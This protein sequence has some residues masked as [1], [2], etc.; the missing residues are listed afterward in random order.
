MKEKIKQI[1]GKIFS[2]TQSLLI[3]IPKTH[4]LVK[5]APRIKHHFDLAHHGKEDI[6]IVL[7]VWGGGAYLLSFFI[8]KFA[9][10]IHIPLIQWIIAIA[11]TAYFAWHIF[12][13]RKCSPKKPPLSDTEKEARKKDR[14]KR[15]IRKLLLKEPITKCDS[16]SIAIAIDVYVIACFSIFLLR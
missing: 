15:F 16:S 11:V 2:K 13:I 10:L 12:V 9:M 4:L 5:Y 1:F 7:W 6:V 14:T 3:L 8:Y